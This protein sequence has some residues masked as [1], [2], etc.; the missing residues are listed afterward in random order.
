MSGRSSPDL[1]KACPDFQTGLCK[2]VW[3]MRQATKKGRKIIK[4][5][6]EKT[7]C[8]Y[9]VQT[10]QN[11]QAKSVKHALILTPGLRL[12]LPSL[13]KQFCSHF[14]FLGLMAQ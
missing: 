4:I 6:E 1:G 5:R 12:V 7:Q 13:R 3:T 14:K 9:E 11:T 10:T 8:I 2:F